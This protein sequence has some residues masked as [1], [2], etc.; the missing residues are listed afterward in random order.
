[1][2]ALL[3]HTIVV[4]MKSVF[5]ISQVAT[6]ADF[7]MCALLAHTTAVQ[8]KYAFLTTQLVATLAESVTIVLMARTVAVQRKFV[9]LISQVQEVA[10]LAHVLPATCGK[11]RTASKYHTRFLVSCKTMERTNAPVGFKLPTLAKLPDTDQTSLNQTSA[12]ALEALCI[13]ITWFQPATYL[14]A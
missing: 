7:A 8:M 4:R 1:M 6:L 14:R 10:T 13:T 12:V 11:A 2:C 3:A 9:L 5:S